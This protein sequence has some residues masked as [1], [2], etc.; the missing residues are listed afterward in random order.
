MHQSPYSV[1]GGHYCLQVDQAVENRWKSS[2]VIELQ[3]HNTELSTRREFLR[4]GCQE[5]VP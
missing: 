2:E 4:E 5:I 3:N 1:T